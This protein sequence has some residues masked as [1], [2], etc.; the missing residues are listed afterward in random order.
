MIY[1]RL[2]RLQEIWL[3]KN[4]EASVTLSALYKDVCCL[5]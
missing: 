1:S 2:E 4:E 3:I 5:S